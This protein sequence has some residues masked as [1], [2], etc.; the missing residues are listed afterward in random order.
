V[1][2]QPNDYDEQRKT[3]KSPDE[4]REENQRNGCVTYKIQW[5]DGVWEVRRVSDDSV[6]TMDEIAGF[7]AQRL[8]HWNRKNEWYSRAMN[9]A[10]LLRDKERAE[11]S[12]RAQREFDAMYPFEWEDNRD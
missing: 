4:L 9:D 12:E 11:A 10:F 3:F 8:A 5:P 1:S 7:E 2:D 6:L